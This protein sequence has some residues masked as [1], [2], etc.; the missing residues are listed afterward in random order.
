MNSITN[1][2]TALAKAHVGT[3]SGVAY[4]LVRECLEAGLIPIE[5]IM[6]VVIGR[7]SLAEI[8]RDAADVCLDSE[9]CGADVEAEAELLAARILSAAKIFETLGDLC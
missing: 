4:D 9:G 7:V 8:L 5:V 6:P 1:M 3:D 2:F